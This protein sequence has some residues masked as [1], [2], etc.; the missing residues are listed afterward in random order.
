M[1]APSWYE[2]SVG[3]HTKD[4]LTFVLLGFVG[5][6]SLKFMMYF[7]AVGFLTM[8]HSEHTYL[9][10]M[11]R[12]LPFT[13]QESNKMTGRA[14]KRNTA[15]TTL[16]PVLAG[17]I[18]A[19]AHFTIIETR[20]LQSTTFAFCDTEYQACV[21]DAE[22]IEQCNPPSGC[23]VQCCNVQFLDDTTCDD[24]DQTICCRLEKSEECANNEAFIAYAGKVLACMRLMRIMRFMGGSGALRGLVHSSAGKTGKWR[25][26]YIN[27]K[28]QMRALTYGSM[29]PKT[30]RIQTN[31]PVE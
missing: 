26:N 20:G 22:C 17:F 21:A 1:L 7:V 29:N 24:L 4:L 2:P 15:T 6:C 18:A 13:A 9:H 3:A 12:S 19:D 10:D 30:T 5:A 8:C 16:L 31:S 28:V 25:W 11:Y 23:S 14:A 27:N